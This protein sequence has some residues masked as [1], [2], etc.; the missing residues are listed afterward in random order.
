MSTATV[1]LSAGRAQSNCMNAA[2]TAAAEARVLTHGFQGQLASLQQEMQSLQTKVECP[3]S[4][5]RQ[6]AHSFSHSSTRARSLTHSLTHSL[7]ARTHACTHTHILTVC[8]NLAAF[9][10]NLQ[11]ILYVL[12]YGIAQLCTVASVMLIAGD[13]SS[14]NAG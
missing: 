2:A 14:Q 1:C 5:A 8:V 12:A 3:P 11:C 10:C 4:L 9:H 13:H 7:H 6:L